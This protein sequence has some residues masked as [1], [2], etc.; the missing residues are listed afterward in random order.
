MSMISRHKSPRQ[1]RLI[2]LLRGGRRRADHSSSPTSERRMTR[3]WYSRPK[4]LMLSGA[5]AFG[6][7]GVLAVAAPAAL[8]NPYI[9][10][11]DGA[12]EV[13][14]T[15]SGYTPGVT[16]R[17]EAFGGWP[18]LLTT[19]YTAPVDVKGHMPDTKVEV[20]PYVGKVLVMADG[21]PGPTAG[22]AANAHPLPQVSAS[23]SGGTLYVS[24]SEFMPNDLVT[25]NLISQGGYGTDIAHQTISADGNGSFPLPYPYGPPQGDALLTGFSGTAFLYADSTH[26][27]TTGTRV[28]C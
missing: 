28:F 6:T 15:G 11:T 5:L 2:A 22:A 8:A 23:C 9:T 3:A 14:V 13:E 18:H 25:L 16:V 20:Q 1:G 27:W 19:T 17:L 21:S 7:L 4:R 24:G 26:G 10:A 12:G